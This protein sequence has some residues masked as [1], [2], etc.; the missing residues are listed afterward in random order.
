MK[1]IAPGVAWLEINGFVNVYFVG[2]RGGPWAL[3]DA[4]M[5]G[6]F[7]TIRDA[8][9]KRYGGGAR[10]EAIYLTHGHYDHAG[11]AAALA[12]HWNVPVYAHRSEMPY[13]TGRSDY[14]PKDPTVGGT[15]A[16]LSRF[17]PASKGFD[18]G[19]TVIEL[20]PPGEALPGMPGW[21]YVETPG[22]A[23]GQVS[24]FR[25]E[26]RTLLAGDA[27][28]TMDLD[29]LT[30]IVTKRQA[31]ARPP[32]PFTYDWVAARRSMYR[33]AELAPVIVG[34]GH[35]VPMAGN[36][37]AEHLARFA[38]D[39]RIP[40]GG[41]YVSEPA[42]TDAERGVVELPPPASDPLVKNM[43]GLGILALLVWLVYRFVLSGKTRN[44]EA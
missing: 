44:E 12:A 30:D 5:P 36:D 15:I 8:A 32:A 24:F 39:F 16:F 14:P 9:Q 13:L 6:Q 2:E 43:A 23:P 17:F 20:P 27:F 4:S 3:V 31:F 1:E 25:A 26:D 35:G 7:E 28:A 42:I 18:L 11:S 19:D 34:C 37:L 10:P 40:G 21:T 22:H 41:R 29:R 33:L 38:E